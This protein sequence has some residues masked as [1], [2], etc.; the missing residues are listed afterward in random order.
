MLDLVKNDHLAIDPTETDSAIEK[1]R[2]MLLAA[3]QQTIAVE[4]IE[5]LKEEVI[6]ISHASLDEVSTNAVDSVQVVEVQAPL[7]NILE[8]ADV[9]EQ[10]SEV[11]APLLNVLEQAGIQEQQNVDKLAN[12]IAVES[13]EER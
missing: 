11:K 3:G 12:V 2:E 7:L 9:Q 4:N 13:M 1:L 5:N 10:E 8:P 6:Q